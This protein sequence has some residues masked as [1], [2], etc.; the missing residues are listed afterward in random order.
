MHLSFIH[1]FVLSFFLYFLSSIHFLQTDYVL[2]LFHL[3]AFF[4]LTFN[5][6]H[7]FFYLHFIFFSL[8]SYP[9]LPSPCFSYIVFVALSLLDLPSNFRRLVSLFFL[10]ISLPFLFP[11]S[12]H[13]FN[14]F[15]LLFLTSFCNHKRKLIHTEIYSQSN[16]CFLTLVNE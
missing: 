16:T 6:F 1:S 11:L 4:V 14:S 3:I 2:T 9:F 10:H 5:F 8:F 7:I 13:I 12:L 15:L